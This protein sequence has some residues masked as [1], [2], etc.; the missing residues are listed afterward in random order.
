MS[1]RRPI[2]ELLSRR[3]G[4]GDA[5]DPSDP[6]RDLRRAL[7]QASRRSGQGREVQ[8]AA[9]PMMGDEFS[10]WRELKLRRGA[11]M[12]APDVER[13]NYAMVLY[14]VDPNSNEEFS[15]WAAGGLVTP[16]MIRQFNL[17]LQPQ[18]AL[19]RML[20]EWIESYPDPILL[21]PPLLNSGGQWRVVDLGIE[22]PVDAYSREHRPIEGA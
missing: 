15:H 18:R 3:P 10:R 9:Q 7:K 6:L 1:R 12:E 14:A 20:A 19:A 21:A 13:G 16:P 8:I 17:G 5:S 2:I 11:I 4:A 22:W